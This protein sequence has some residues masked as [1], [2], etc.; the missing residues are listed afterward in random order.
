[1]EFAELV[2]FLRKN[3]GVITLTALS[4]ALISCVLYFVLPQKY[5]AAGSLFIH[6]TTDKNTERF[7]TYEG[8]YGQQTA[9]AYTNTVAGILES[10]DIKS[11]ALA[12]LEQNVTEQTLRTISKQIKVKKASPQLLTLT[13]KSNTAQNGLALWEY[14][15]R[16]TIELADKLNK[17][18][19]PALQISVLGNPVVKTQY[20]NILINSVI[21]LGFGFLTATFGLALT[22]FIKDSFSKGAK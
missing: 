12:H 1:M 18:G 13:V 22:G 19:D 17:N 14:M 16:Q 11:L 8:Y 15:A 10:T 2:V 5:I 7:F 6:R 21:G 4:G 20:R 9:I 3:L